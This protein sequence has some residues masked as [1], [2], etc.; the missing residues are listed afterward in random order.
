MRLKHHPRWLT[1]FIDLVLIMLGAMALLITNNLHGPSVVDAVSETFGGSQL[2]MP[3]QTF[4]ID[5]LFEE[6]EAR[7]TASGVERLDGFSK[8]AAEQD[9]RV[10]IHVP[11][12]IRDQDRLQ[13]WE[14]AAARTASIGYRLRQGGLTQDRIVLRIP[15]AKT[16]STN[17]QIVLEL[18]RK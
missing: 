14:L 5:Q 9:A 13:G 4:G 17:S 15:E 10:Y 3:G 18:R 2:V 8:Q 7:L 12:E 6:N 16:E 11:F 1:S